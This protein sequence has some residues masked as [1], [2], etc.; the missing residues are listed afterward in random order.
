MNKKVFV[1]Y[2]EIKA[3]DLV[4]DLGEFFNP[5]V[6]LIVDFDTLNKIDENSMVKIEFTDN[7]IQ[8]VVEEK[9]VDGFYGPHMIGIRQSYE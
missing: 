3:C 4:D 1:N 2:V 9:I 7:V 6:Y 8:G 5:L